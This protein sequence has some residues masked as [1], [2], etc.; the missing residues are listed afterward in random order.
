MKYNIPQ[1]KRKKITEEKAR[2]ILVTLFPDKYS[3]SELSESPDIIDSVHKIGVEVTSSLKSCIQQDLSR[4][5]NICGKTEKELDKNDKTNIKE[6]RVITIVLPNGQYCAAT[7]AHWG[8][9]HDFETI[10]I[11]K[12]DKLN[13]EHFNC[14][15]ENNLFIDSSLIDKDELELAIEY[16]QKNCN[17]NDDKKQFD[18]IY[19]FVEYAIFEIDMHTGDYK[20]YDI[21]HSDLKKFSN[22]AFEKIMGMSLDEFKE[23]QKSDTLYGGSKNRQMY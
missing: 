19:I 23:K 22:N 8:D 21:A 4:A 16:F 14:F 15:K 20:Q 6:G 13:R 1:S 2:Q 7:N 11:K 10:Y 12:I 17:K 9:E 18:Y 3:N 5:V